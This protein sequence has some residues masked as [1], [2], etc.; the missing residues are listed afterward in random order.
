[1]RPSTKLKQQKIIE[2]AT[3]LFLEQGYNQTNLD[4]VIEQCGGSKQTI[5][6]YFGDKRGLLMAV[7]GRC[8][9][10]VEAIFNFNND[11][12]SDLEQQLLQFGTNYLN[13][14]LTPTMVNTYRIM[15]TES[16]HD[17]SLAD[18]YL[19]HGPQRITN[20]LAQFLQSHMDKGNLIQSDSTMA[21]QHLLN[22]LKGDIHHDAL[23]GIALPNKKNIENNV[24]LAV[25]CFLNGYAR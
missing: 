4:Q 24:R 17:S 1:M 21:C 18:F 14:I 16:Q 19:S 9:E 10:N 7:I 25:N 13:T 8:I 2:V 11:E 12:N 20:Y 15:I 6:N 23:F 22:L 3:Q 5:Y